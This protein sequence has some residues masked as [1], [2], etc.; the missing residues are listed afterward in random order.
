MASVVDR[1][2][3]VPSRLP[4]RLHEATRNALWP[5][6]SPVTS[7]CEAHTPRLAR[8]D[9]RQELLARFALYPIIREY[10]DRGRAA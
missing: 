9:A 6:V 10:E 5:N 4:V 1:S 8:I 2:D 3:V 7:T